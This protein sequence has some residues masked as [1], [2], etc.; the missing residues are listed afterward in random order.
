[1]K[2]RI[3]F[4]A[5][6]VGLNLSGFAQQ[7]KHFSMFAESPVYLNPAAAGF[8]PGN[9]Q[10]FSNFRMQWMSV[11]A[12]PFQT[13]SASADWR[14]MD[15]GSF[16]GAGINFHNDISGDSKY[17]TNEVSFPI[18]Y[19]IELGRDNHFSIGLQPGWYQRTI[20]NQNVTWDN[21]WTG[22]SFN[23]SYSSNEVLLNEKMNVS[24]FDIG[25][26][27]YWYTN[28]SK[29]TRLSFGIA[30]S[31]LTKQ[32]IN[33]MN[34]DN[35]LYRK[36]TLHGQCSFTQSNSNLTIIPAFYTFFQGPNKEFTVGSNFR[37]LL[38]GSSRV[39]GH[40]EEITLSLGAYYRI[41]DALLTNL[42]FQISGLSIGAAYDLNLSRLNIASNGVGG[43]EFFLR[44]RIQFGKGGMGNPSIH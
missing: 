14:M 33:F 42:I 44:Y 8:F 24:R 16:L 21:Q 13:I 1:M 40:F 30:G 4:L 41:G 23:T 2:K 36:L 17:M 31:H 25:A 9:L 18:N 28:I 12:T 19:A 37:F 32:K 3:G 22:T 38:R 26:G 27:A 20:V 39:T 7:D 15:R 34:D 29:Q 11:S 35:K 10:L 6:V 5:L 43:F